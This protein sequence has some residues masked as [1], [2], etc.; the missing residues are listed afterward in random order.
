MR[1]FLQFGTVLLLAVEFMTFA[2][3]IFAE[4]PVASVKAKEVKPR[5][6]PH[7]QDQPPNDPREPATAV[8]MMTVPEGFTVELVAS[9]IATLFLYH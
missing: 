6:I 4:Q 2:N 9:E 5:A 8:S 1:H 3:P 7:A